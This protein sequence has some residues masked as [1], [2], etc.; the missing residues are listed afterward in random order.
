MN[1]AATAG[2]ELPFFFTHVFPWALVLAGLALL[3]KSL[4]ELI[5][6]LAS[7][8]WPT[9][10]GR[11]L[12]C[13]RDSYSVSEDGPPSGLPDVEYSYSV[14]GV[15]HIGT[16][17]SF[18][19]LAYLGDGATAGFVKKHPRG[20]KVRVFYD[21]K[22]PANSLLEPG[23]RV[24]VFTMLFFAALIFSAG[25]ALGVLFGAWRW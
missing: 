19:D 13:V 12:K 22:N 25:V 5:R 17:I 3:R 10:E 11:I 14:D 1:Q 6:A 4:G 8:R 2:T 20:G 18:A 7:K 16:R 9:A 24:Q 21:P 23:I 15:D